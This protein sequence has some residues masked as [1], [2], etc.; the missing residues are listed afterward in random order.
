MMPEKSPY[1]TAVTGW[2]RADMLLALYN[3]AIEQIELAI[4][5]GPSSIVHRTRAAA[6]V[7]AIRTGIDTDVDELSTQID[8][9]CEFVQH[10]LAEGDAKRMQSALKV[11]Q[12]I[13]DGFEGVRDDAN[14]REQTGEIPALSTQATVDASV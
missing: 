9:L 10:C 6:L 12:E 1:E 4:A 7:T 2:T 14:R 13:R 8:Q 3:G 11:L 5:D